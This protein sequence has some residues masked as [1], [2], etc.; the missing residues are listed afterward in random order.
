MPLIKRWVLS[1]ALLETG[2]R[3]QTA[4]LDLHNYTALLVFSFTMIPEGLQKQTLVTTETTYLGL[5]VGDGV[6]EPVSMGP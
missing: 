5:V 1:R 4:L 2:Q 6:C 3:K